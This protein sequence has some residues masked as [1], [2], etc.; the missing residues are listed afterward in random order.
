M[1]G[2][3][4]RREIEAIIGRSLL[5]A[6]VFATELREELVNLS[7]AGILTAARQV[8]DRWEPLLAQMLTEAELAAWVAGTD[9]VVRILPSLAREALEV[10]AGLPPIGRVTALL[11]GGPGEPIISFPLIERAAE[12][13]LERNIVSRPEFDRLG[14]EARA[15]AFTV[16]RQ[17]SEDAISTIRDVLAET[18]DQGASLSEFRKRLGEGLDGSFIGPS[19]RETVYRTN[20]QAAFT[21]AHD[22]LAD[23]PIVREVFPFREYLPIKDGRTRD[24][25]LALATLGLDGTG[26]YF[27]SDPFWDVFSIPWAFNCLLPNTKVS[28]NIQCAVRSRYSGKAVE[29]TTRRG[30]QITTTAKHPIL[31]TV[32]LIPADELCRGH[33]VLCDRREGRHGKTKSWP[34]A[35]P[36]SLETHEQDTP[37][38]AEKI[39]RSLADRRSIASVPL[40]PHNLHGDAQ[41]WNGNVDVVWANGELRDNDVAG[42]L[43]GL[44]NFVLTLRLLVQAMLR[45]QCG[46]S[47]L[48]HGPFHIPASIG[49]FTGGQFSP[50]QFV[51]RTSRSHA[52]ALLMKMVAND[53]VSAI[54]SVSDIL[55]AHSAFVHGDQIADRESTFRTWRPMHPSFNQ[56]PLRPPAADHV[57]LHQIPNSFSANIATDEIIDVRSTEY[58]GHVYDFQ[59]TT[60]LL[61]A[62]GIIVGNCRC[63]SN[64][65]S[66]E[67]AA[68]K[69][70]VEARRWE[71]TGEPPVNPEHRLNAIPFRPEPDFVGGRRLSLFVRMAQVHAPA[72]GVSIG[73][74]K[75]KGGEFIPGDVIEKAT[76]EEKAK[77][78]GKGGEP[79]ERKRKVDKQTATPQFKKWFGDSKVVDDSG[80]PLRVFHGTGAEFNKFTDRIAWVTPDAEFAGRYADFRRSEGGS[81]QIIPLF[82]KAEHPV[83]VSV[84]PKRRRITKLL[85]DMLAEAKKQGLSFDAKVAKERFND[86]RETWRRIGLDEGELDVFDHW[87]LSGK[88]GNESLVS[89]AKALGFDSIRHEEQGIVTYGIF[90]G[91]QLKSATGNRG[92]FDANNPDIRMAVA[93]V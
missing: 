51:G 22:E 58:R 67:A 12:S 8:L 23:N 13:L 59:S 62:N 54:K 92:T 43:E 19:H 11:T 75:F 27:A 56:D 60:G 61:T 82:A 49:S 77:V 88:I 86:V 29:I 87:N 31:T 36:S 48:S 37:L 80:Q 83:E 33:R 74:K 17:D 52:N 14:R 32:G 21:Q 24:E 7:P 65:L 57:N 69:G 78:E 55:G 18:I 26:V 90:E 45:R 79:A 3:A 41:P 70:V 89:Y 40:R 35:E 64:L 34:L 84:R 46:P 16:A 4:K 91:P 68:R 53:F 47:F 1:P 44:R 85:T 9:A 71:R 25:H 76:E 81:A 6:E 38:E 42:K 20:I 2:D 93:E 5:T 73:G 72:G 50:R 39:F 15:R 63:G 30:H 66:V 10:S 28:G